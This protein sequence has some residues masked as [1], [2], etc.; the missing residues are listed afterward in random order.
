MR[1]FLLSLMVLVLAATSSFS[2][3]DSLGI[4]KEGDKYFVIHKVMSGQTLY[5]LARRYGTTVTEI[6]AKNAELVN[7]LKV[8]QTINIPYGKP[9]GQAE[10]PI[11]TSVQASKTHTVAAGETLFAISQ[12]YGVDVNEIKKLNGLTSNALA[13]GQTLKISVAAKT[14]QE[15]TLP[16]TTPT[17]K[18]VTKP[19]EKPKVVDTTQKVTNPV[20]TGAEEITNESYN[21]SPFNEIIEE[22]QAELIIEDESSTKFLALHKT[23]KV[24]TVIKVKNR[25]NNLT[26][27]VRVVGEIPDT[28][29]NQNILIK[30]NKR[31]YDQLK[32][33]DNRF[34][35]ELSYFQ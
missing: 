4:K 5:S 1:K 14:T 3:A 7:D 20:N 10:I 13:V 26:V 2:Q 31:A 34:L 9:M 19:I 11:K 21:G 28:A 24:G 12:K 17:E 30:L 33:L 16:T 8:G 35:V 32:A 6:K 15:V 25:M 23:A 18:S 22:G 29:D 27:Y